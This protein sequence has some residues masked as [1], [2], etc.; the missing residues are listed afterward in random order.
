VGGGED[1]RRPRRGWCGGRRGGARASRRALALHALFRLGTA[2]IHLRHAEMNIHVPDPV[3]RDMAISPVHIKGRRASTK[4]LSGKHFHS[5]VRRGGTPPRCP[6]T[7]VSTHIAAPLLPCTRP[8]GVRAGQN[9]APSQSFD[10]CRECD[11]NALRHTSA[12]VA[13]TIALLRSPGIFLESLGHFAVRAKQAM[14]CS[15]DSRA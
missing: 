9:S 4:S 13:W 10:R 5:I 14:T 6:D 3:L 11:A 7:L 2:S 1:G 8:S 15:E 12:L